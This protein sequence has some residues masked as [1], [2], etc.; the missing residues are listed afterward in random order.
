MIGMESNRQRQARAPRVRSSIE[1]RLKILAAQPS[2]LDCDIDSTVTGSPIWRAMD[3]L[4]TS[5]PG[6]GE[7]TVRTL[8]AGL[9]ELGQLDRRRI[10]A[11]VGVA[12]VNRNSGQMRGRR[13][14]VC[15]RR[16]VRS[17]L[18]TATLVAT[19]WNPV[20]RQALP[21]FSCPRPSPR[22]SLWWRACGIFSRSSMRYFGR[23]PPGVPCKGPR[24]RAAS[25]A[26]RR[27]ANPS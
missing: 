12:P 15:G 1:T 7:I 23:K 27:L 4:L 16:D 20:I 3:D 25:Q 8:I 19:R 26:C 14:V 18:F 6:V 9:P 22:K 21:D 5:V 17:V 11:L 24:H 2:G 10:A 13:S